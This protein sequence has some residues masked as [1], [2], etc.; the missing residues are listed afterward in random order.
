MRAGAAALVVAAVVGG[1]TLPGTVAVA[2][3]MGMPGDI[4][5]DGYR[6]LVIPAP[7]A[8]VSGKQYAGAVVVLYGSAHGVS[9]ARRTVVTQDSPGVPGAAERGDHFGASTALADLD[10]D[11]YA[12]LVVGAPLEDVGSTADV[13]SVTV[14]WGGR[15]GLGA[16]TTLPTLLTAAGS[17]A[18]RDVAAWSGASGAQV[19]IA[20]W[21][22]ATHLAGPFTRTGKV[23]KATLHDELPWMGMVAL[24]DVNGDSAADRVT[25]TGRAGGLSGGYVA[26]NAE[27]T[28]INPQLVGD[29][30]IPAVGDVNG[31]GYGDVVVGDP[32]EPSADGPFGHVGGSVHV[33]FGSAKGVSSTAQPMSITQDTPGVPGTGE[34]QDAFGAAVAVADLNRDGIGD[35]VVGVPGEGLGKVAGAGDVMVVPGRRSGQLGSGSYSFSQSTA[36]VPGGS[37]DGDMFGSTL[38]VGDTDRNGYPEITVGAAGENSSQGAVWVFPGAASHPSYASAVMMGPTS[39]GLPSAQL[40]FLG[41]ESPAM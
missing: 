4:N 15:S 38:A 27:R 14:L 18:G 31:D 6:D 36:G 12:D 1:V 26:V 29:G 19:M 28:D 32:D 30:L 3:P 24:G 17:R 2:A 5:G 25:V 8:T 7:G 40:T 23:G 22:G 39:V 41:G 33:W 37:E 16:G 13:G 10:R 20:D 9:A 34:R 11:G 35:I 21:N